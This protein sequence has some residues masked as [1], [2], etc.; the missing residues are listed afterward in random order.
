MGDPEIWVKG[1]DAAVGEGHSP[2]VPK[3]S[4]TP[5]LPPGTLGTARPLCRPAPSAPGAPGMDSWP[6]ADGW[7]GHMSGARA[8]WRRGCWG[9]DCLRAPGV[10]GS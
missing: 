6:W 8:G 2:A 7:P 10:G 1:M 3:A 9:Q 5:R 4:S